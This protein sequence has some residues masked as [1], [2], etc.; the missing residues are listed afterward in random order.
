MKKSPFDLLGVLVSTALALS[1]VAVALTAVTTVLGSGSL[2]GL[3]SEHLCF[4][5]T[6]GIAR[7]GGSGDQVAMD[8]LANVQSTART[9][10][11]CVD[12]PT[13]GQRGLGV[14]TNA[15]T[16]GCYLGALFLLSRLIR[17]SERRGI[18][19]IATSTRLR[20]LGYFLLVGAPLA[21]LVESFARTTLLRTA[22]TYE[23][24]AFSFVRDWD[25]P[26]WAV[27]TGLGLIAFA[28]IMRT[29]AEM[30]EE[31]EGTV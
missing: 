6:S 8:V 7:V 12:D 11:I 27:F 13:G 16:T 28:K 10:S 24:G 20:A 2:F 25:L 19:T 23:P 26:W 17:Q 5:A 4:E 30:R 1:A 29:S 14:L 9:V 31:L 3:G 21:T 18:H 15:P 22:V